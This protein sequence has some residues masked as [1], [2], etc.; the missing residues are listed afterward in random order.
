MGGVSRVACVFVDYS[1]LK[2]QPGAGFVTSPRYIYMLYIYGGNGSYYMAGYLIEGRWE[3][4]M[5]YN[6]MLSREDSRQPS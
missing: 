1:H 3:E 6:L 4:G 5:A 2:F